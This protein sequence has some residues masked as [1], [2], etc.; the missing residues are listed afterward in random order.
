MTDLDLDSD[1]SIRD[2]AGYFGARRTDGP[3]QWS[4]RQ[5][6]WVVLDHAEV[7]DAFRETETLS[8]DRITALERVA[9]DRPAAFVKVVDLLR[10]WMVFRDPPAH[11]RLRAPMRNVFTPRRVGDMHDL[12]AEV[13]DDV[14]GGLPADGFE[15]RRDFGSPLPALVIAAILG[16]EREDRAK[17]QAWSDDLATI[18]FSAQPSATEPARAISATE[19]FSAFFGGL[20]NRERENPGDSLLSTLVAEADDELTAMEL[21][22]ACTLVLF[23]GHE[24]TASLLTNTVGALLERP[25]LM[26]W[27][28]AH[29]EA[30]ATAIE[31]LL[32]VV[33]PARTMFRKAAVDH[34]RGGASVKAGQT[35][36]ICIAAANHDE[37]MIADP[38]RIDLTRDPNP[39]YAFGW[40]L[41]H[42]VGSHL[43]RL[44]AQLAMRALFNRFA[45]LEPVGVVPPVTGTVLGYAREPMVVG[46]GWTGDAQPP[47]CAHRWSS[48]AGVAAEHP[49]ENQDQD[50][51]EH[52]AEEP[53][54]G[55]LESVPGE[56]VE[57][58]A[59]HQRADHAQPDGTDT[60]QPAVAGYD[61]PGQH[62]DN[63]ATDQP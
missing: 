23:G 1:E 17:F 32:R 30:D 56:R 49:G 44:E 47:D 16:V 34:Q 25:G 50:G 22:G 19:E 63:E 6:A 55:R 21:V 45:V 54:A 46:A 61:H 33:G 53:A 27:W 29:P 7:G 59:T 31:E 18:V 15:V 35:V 13:V 40:G 43:A 52:R 3:V 26:A 48:A 20:I 12:V 4:E 14:V 28:R 37:S 2:P 58:G 24:T 11:T 41:H 36:A 42:C 8:A 38:G 39:H 51:A 10:G 57:S 9:R 5:R 60:A 62:P